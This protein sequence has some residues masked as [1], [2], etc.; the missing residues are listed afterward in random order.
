VPA[1]LP[2]RLVDV[3]IDRRDVEDWTGPDERPLPRSHAE[4]GEP[5]AQLCENGATVSLVGDDAIFYS[6]TDDDYVW[7]GEW[8]SGDT[9]E[10]AEA[11]MST[12]VAAFP[13]CTGD[14]TWTPV[15]I[16][17]QGVEEVYRFRAFEGI[18]DPAGLEFVYARNGGVIALVYVAGNEA[19]WA[20]DD[21]ALVIE[22]ALARLAA[23]GRVEVDPTRTD[24]LPL[25]TTT[26][27][28]PALTDVLLHPQD[29]ANTVSTKPIPIPS[30]ADRYHEPNDLLFD[31]NE[32]TCSA[33][34]TIRPV[35]DLAVE[36][37][38]V[39]ADNSIDD[40]RWVVNWVSLETSAAAETRF[41]TTVDQLTSCYRTADG[42]ETGEI[43]RT[44]V[45]EAWQFQRTG[46]LYQY[47]TIVYARRGGVLSL[48]WI[49]EDDATWAPVRIDDIVDGMLKRLA[50]AD[51]S[52]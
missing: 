10:A 5:P 13:K 1:V 41:A 6:M 8:V 31:A 22:A 52:D 24:Q 4:F 28:D 51:L 43:T 35:A 26:V 9:A 2:E 33:D 36:S 25:P 45:D 46:S 50:T 20:G 16:D 48:V 40:F 29:I 34:D 11:Q 47:K 19:D 42:W 3:L 32:L 18:D 30:S 27:P 21:K 39:H 23:A 12:A 7:A 49:Q 37:S 44:D 14:M 15:P 17:R 38:I